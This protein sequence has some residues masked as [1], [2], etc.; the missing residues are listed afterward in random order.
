MP[1]GPTTSDTWL[2]V[3][4]EAAPR[5]STWRD[6]VRRGWARGGGVEVEV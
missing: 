4:P 1:S 5:Y 6:E 2:T 3:V